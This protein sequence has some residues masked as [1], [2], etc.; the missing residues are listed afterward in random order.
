MGT[1]D[2]ILNGEPT[3]APE[4]PVTEQQP[5]PQ[6]EV[7]EERPRDEHGRFVAKETDRNVPWKCSHNA[8]C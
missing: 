4:E 8:V 3:D 5:E 2:D 7:V 6:A 1:I